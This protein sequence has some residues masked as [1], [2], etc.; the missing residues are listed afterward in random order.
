MTW[1]EASY[2]SAYGKVKSR[3]EKAAGGVKFTFIV[4][5]NT[6]ADVILPNGTRYSVAAGIHTFAA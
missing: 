4:P 5:A 1:A 6:T 2:Y 3:W